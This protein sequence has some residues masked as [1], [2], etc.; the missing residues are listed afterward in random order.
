MPSVRSL[1][2]CAAVALGLVAGSVAGAFAAF[3]STAVNGGNAITSVPDFSAPD[4]VAVAIGAGEGGATG[5]VAEGGTYH[6]YANVLPDGGNPP[7]G[8]ASVTADVGEVTAGATAVP[9]VAGSY[10]AGGEPYNHRSDALT[11]DS[12]LAEGVAAFAVT[13]VDDASNDETEP[14]TV[15]VDNGGP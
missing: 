4:V 7:S 2:L 10:V 13:A 14:G 9:L 15:T 11:A 3:G 12:P 6:V 8:T 5:S 1:V